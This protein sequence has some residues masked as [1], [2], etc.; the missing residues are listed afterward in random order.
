MNELEATP[1][2]VEPHVLPREDPFRAAINLAEALRRI[3]REGAVCGSLNPAHIAWDKSGVRLYQNG[4]SGLTPYLSP[5][6]LR[7]EAADARSD[8][9][10]FGAIVYGCGSFGFSD[11]QGMTVASRVRKQPTTLLSC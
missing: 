5:E 4:A 6:Q 2:L 1:G 9:F 3:H 11:S 10:A 8:I 7:G